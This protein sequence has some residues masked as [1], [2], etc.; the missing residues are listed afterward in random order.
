[1]KSENKSAW[2]SL[3]EPKNRQLKDELQ[4]SVDRL[5]TRGYKVAEDKKWWVIQADRDSYDKLSAYLVSV[6]DGFR[7]K[8]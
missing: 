6:W 5:T 2:K 1:M 3:N 7:N 8:H 4:A